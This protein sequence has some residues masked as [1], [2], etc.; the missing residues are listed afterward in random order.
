LS[1]IF[2]GPALTANGV[3]FKLNVL[4]D[5]G[6]GGEAFIHP[7]LLLAVRKYFQIKVLQI[8]TAES[9]YPDSITNTPAQSRKCSSWTY[10]LLDGVSQPGS[11]FVIPEGMIS[12]L[13]TSG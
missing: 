13:D 3:Q 11:S 9:G 1:D 12:S 4:I 7:K 2:G 5:S 8:R 6:V 10:S